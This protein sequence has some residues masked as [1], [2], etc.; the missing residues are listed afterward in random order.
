MLENSSII[1]RKMIN[2][3]NRP[4]ASGSIAIVD[5]DSLLMRISDM[6]IPLVFLAAFSL[7]PAMLSIGVVRVSLCFQMLM[8]DNA[9]V[10]KK[11]KQHKKRTPTKTNQK[12]PYF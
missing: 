11:Q 4:I 1:K 3:L 9:N 10:Y 8:L 12:K 2:C 5:Q 6:G 7:V